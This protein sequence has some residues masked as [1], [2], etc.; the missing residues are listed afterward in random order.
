MP[1]IVVG[2]DGSEHSLRA[3][4]WAVREA[5]IRQAP[6]T[7]ITVFRSV[8]GYWGAAVTY[9]EDHALSEQTGKDAQEAV[10]KAVADAGEPAPASV[11]VKVVSGIA[12]EELISASEDADL[13]VVGSRGSGGFARL[14]LGSVSNQVVHHAR[15]P[16]V[17]IP[18][19][20]RER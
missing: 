12:A 11:T 15:C 14:L 10:E 13:L 19:D 5:G 7:V 6:L 18:A 20:E 2:I 8:V 9:P 1:G 4:D 3:L 16:V 17:V